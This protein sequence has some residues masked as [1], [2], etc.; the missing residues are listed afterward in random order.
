M[1]PASDHAKDTVEHLTEAAGVAAAD[2]NWDRV[3]DCYQRREV[4]LSQA[5]LSPEAL[6]RVMTL[7]CRIE[8]QIKIAQAGLRSLLDEAATT[9]QRIQGLRRW[10]GALSSDSGTIERHV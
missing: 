5:R 3:A 1:E 7:D 9:R 4:I 10:N 8:E 2:G 6:T